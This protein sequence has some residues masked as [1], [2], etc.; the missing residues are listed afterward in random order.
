M[1]FHK[2]FKVRMYPNK[3]QAILI[4]KTLGSVRFVYNYFL[5]MKIK[6]YQATGKSLPCLLIKLAGMEEL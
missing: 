5:D 4:N 1:V 2:T 6:T 3:E